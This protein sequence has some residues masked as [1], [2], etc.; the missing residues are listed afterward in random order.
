MFICD[1]SNPFNYSAGKASLSLTSRLCLF[2]Q[3]SL[4]PETVFPCRW[5]KDSVV[6]C[7]QSLWMR[8]RD[9]EQWFLR[10][11]NLL[12]PSGVSPKTVRTVNLHQKIWL[13]SV[14]KPCSG[15]VCWPF[16]QAAAKIRLQQ[17][18]QTRINV[19]VLWFGQT[20]RNSSL[21]GPNFGQLWFG[22][23]LSNWNER[24]MH[25]N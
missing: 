10:V 11:S 23:E 19:P 18:S 9:R 24:K 2:K 12:A 17:I 20:H 1:Y 6:G 15:T 21:L 4:P 3:G 13:R 5:G 22:V 16:Q 14:R 25:I 7:S 8:D